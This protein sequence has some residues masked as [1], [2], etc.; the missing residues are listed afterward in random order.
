M[1]DLITVEGG[2]DLADG[3]IGLLEEH[4][5]HPLDKE[6]GT[7]RVIVIKGDEKCG[8]AQ[9]ARTPAVLSALNDRRIVEVGTG[10]E[11]KV[12]A[13]DQR[14]LRKLADDASK[15]Q[16]AADA[17][18]ENMELQQVATSARTA[19]EDHEQVMASKL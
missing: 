4:P 9:V 3:Q 7:R 12:T 8:K 13:E 19:L 10:F 16:K 5:A 17:K 11:A 6:A 14:Q 18:P 1:A 2:P 15:A